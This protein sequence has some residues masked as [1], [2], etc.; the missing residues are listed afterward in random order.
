M[1]S[2]QSDPFITS[3]APIRWRVERQPVRRL[4]N[5]RLVACLAV[6][7]NKRDLEVLCVDVEDSEAL[8]GVHRQGLR[9]RL[10]GPVLLAGLGGNQK[11]D[12]TCGLEIL[13]HVFMAGDVKL[14]G[15]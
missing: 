10:D 12:A 9:A 3:V 1:A 13:N 2:H 8:E 4:R 5:V 14:R 11:L 7:V 15:P 6:G